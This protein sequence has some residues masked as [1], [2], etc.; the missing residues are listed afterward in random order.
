MV[1]GWQGDITGNT[2][3]G[4]AC[5]GG[6]GGSVFRTVSSGSVGSDQGLQDEM[7]ADVR[8]WLPRMCYPEMRSVC[9]VFIERT[10]YK[11]TMC[12][13]GLG[14]APLRA[15]LWAR[16]VA[17]WLRTLSSADPAVESTACLP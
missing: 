8:A 12:Y 4:N 16:T 15:A 3:S 2:F 13:G 17:F 11:H 14:F 9:G 1:L 5:Q 10:H 7:D 6:R